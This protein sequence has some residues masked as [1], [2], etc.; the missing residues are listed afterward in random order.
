M[1]E[2]EVVIMKYVSNKEENTLNEPTLTLQIRPAE[3]ERLC[4][5]STNHCLYRNII[6]LLICYTTF[7]GY[8]CAET[9]GGLEDTIIKVMGID[10]TQY[11][12]L[13][14]F[15]ALPTIVTSIFGGVLADKILGPRST[16]VIVVGITALGQ[17]VS[18]LG[19]FTNQFWVVLGGR[20]FIGIGSTLVT[21]VAQPFMIKWFGK[22]RLTFAMSVRSTAARL[23][24]A[25]ALGLPQLI[26]NQLYYVNKASYRLGIT[27]TIGLCLIIV[28]IGTALVVNLMDRR[29]KRIPRP[30]NKEN[31]IRCGDLRQ[32]PL[33]FW[34]MVFLM[35][36]YSVVFAFTGIGQG[37]YV[38]KYGL[39]LET[40]SI[41]N[42]FVF[43][44][45][46][47]ATPVI[48]YIVNAIGYHIL[49][50]IGGIISGLIVHI[51]LLASNPGLTY[52]PYITGIMYSF[53]FTIFAAS[54]WPL[55]GLIVE[56]NQIATAYGIL[57]STQNLFWAVFSIVSGAVIDSIGYFVLEV[58]YVS[59]NF[60]VVVV[61]VWLLMVDV[62]SKN[63]VVNAPG[64]WVARCKEKSDNY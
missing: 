49:W 8:Y 6:L 52:V 15:N 44:A 30:K 16:Y 55:A 60:L 51:V 28:G 11:N 54:Y 56:A 32:F 40:A 45:T 46:I 48:G 10:T 19:S 9:P 35:T 41:A 7:L 31:K 38:Q 23:G 62:F 13:F 14:V 36:Y 1:A 59:I 18:T 4:C 12:L 20:V 64:T 42:S 17:L 63:A 53:S 34:L 2:D 50:T 26:Y 3:P 22:G 29:G 58:T 21:A 57:L 39:S 25:T 33:Q 24:G 61:A 37:F 43:S 47:L 27:L 5:I